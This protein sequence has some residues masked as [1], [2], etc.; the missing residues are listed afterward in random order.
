MAKFAHQDIIIPSPTW[1]QPIVGKILELSRLRDKRITAYSVDV[2]IEL[3]WIFQDLE[4]W[5][6]ARIEGNQTELID[7]LTQNADVDKE[8]AKTTDY[9]EV[10]NLSKATRYIDEY[11][12]NPNNEINEKFILEIHKI[13]VDGL[14]VGKNLPGDAT[15]GKTRIKNVTIT[16][17]N[18]QPPMGIKV[19]DYFADLSE[20]INQDHDIKDDF[21]KIAIAHH[22]FT[23]IHPFSNG[24]GRIARLL[25]YAMLQKLGYEVRR[26][27]ILNPSLV[28]NSDREKYY[29]MLAAADLG[30]P[31]GLLEWC[32]YFVDGLLDEIKKIDRLLDARYVRERIL[33]PVL[34]QAYDN[35][36]L[37]TQ[38]YEILKYSISSEGMTF[39]AGDLDRALNVKFKPYQRTRIVNKMK[40]DGL[41]QLAV[42][43]KQKYVIKLNSSLL[44]RYSTDV[45]VD[46]GFIEVR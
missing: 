10:K 44:V 25:T 41:I 8:V 3:K 21:L 11:L 38:E 36:R 14:P 4:N 1:D 42:D 17:S 35:K 2:F 6:S 37:S 9:Q 45:I 15:P 16:K 13:V 12:A 34:N 32:T 22:R 40:N 29:D 30:T 26:A 31:A 33:T 5:A 24:N 27:H 28:F 23:W 7:A 43:S 46:E 39:T 18:H 19:K 20:F